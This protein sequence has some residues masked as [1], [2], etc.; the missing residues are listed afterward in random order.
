M[1]IAMIHNDQRITFAVIA[2]ALSRFSVS[3]N[4]YVIYVTLRTSLL[5]P[6]V[7]SVLAVYMVKR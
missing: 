7:F 2:D 6:T 4:Y 3:G 5:N 1:S